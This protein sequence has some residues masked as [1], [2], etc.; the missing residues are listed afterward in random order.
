[1]TGVLMNLGAAM[2]MIIG[3]LGTAPVAQYLFAQPEAIA[4]QTAAFCVRLVPGV[5]PQ[6]TDSSTSSALCIVPQNLFFSTTS[7]HL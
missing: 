1:M 2:P 7:F 3:L 5:L 4:Q 6:V